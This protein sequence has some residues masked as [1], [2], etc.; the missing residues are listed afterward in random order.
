LGIES[1]WRVD[2]VELKVADGEVHIHLM[3]NL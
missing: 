3:P 1:P 2:R